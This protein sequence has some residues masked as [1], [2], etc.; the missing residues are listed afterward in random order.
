[1][2]TINNKGNKKVIE[3]M[4]NTSIH[5]SL[6]TTSTDITTTWVG[7]SPPYTQILSIP[8]I[9]TTNEVHISLSASATQAQTQEYDNLELKSGG[10]GSGTVTLR[11]WGS[12]NSATVPID[13]SVRGV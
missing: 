12:K 5:S 13:V 3:H 7:S 6:Y 11:C 10:Q 4:G 8:A 1:M 2:I 9:S